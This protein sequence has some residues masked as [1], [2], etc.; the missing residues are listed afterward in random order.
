MEHRLIGYKP[1]IE[2]IVRTHGEDFKAEIEEIKPD[3]YGGT[4]QT[5]I[6]SVSLR[7]VFYGEKFQKFDL[8]ELGKLPRSLVSNQ[9]LSILL[10]CDDGEKLKEGFKMERNGK[11]FRVRHMRKYFAVCYQAELEM[12]K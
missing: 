7:G 8:M 12:I 6:I 10:T 11:I 2:H 4:V 9:N 5:G 1:L 3:G